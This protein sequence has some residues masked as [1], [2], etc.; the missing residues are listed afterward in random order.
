MGLSTNV[1]ELLL[2]CNRAGTSRAYQSAW[3]LWIDWSRSGLFDPMSPSLAQV[4]EYLSFLFASGKAYRTINVHRSMLSTTLPAVDGHEIGKHPLVCRLLKGIF[5]RRTPE[6]RYSYFWDADM[7]IGKLKEL[8]PNAEL[9]MKLATYKTALL[10]ALRRMLERQNWRAL[11]MLTYA[12]KMV[13]CFLKFLDLGR[14]SRTER[15]QGFASRSSRTTP[16]M[17][18]CKRPLLFK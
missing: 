4:L 9:S 1:S 14:H 3:K 16:R 17:P 18:G 2:E 5:N 13:K 15:C 6:S 7:V 12:K 8:G 10:L 11:I